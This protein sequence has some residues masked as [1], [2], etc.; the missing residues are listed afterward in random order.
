MSFF[1]PFAFVKSATIPAPAPVG[2]VANIID[3][4]FSISACYPGTGTTVTDLYGGFTGSL[5]NNPT[6]D[7]T[8]GSF[9]F[10]VSVNNQRISFPG[11]TT[12]YEIPPS[13]SATWNVWCSK[14]ST[15]DNFLLNK[16]P[17]AGGGTNQPGNYELASGF[18]NNRAAFITNKAN[19]ALNYSLPAGANFFG[20]GTDEWVN[21]II[22]STYNGGTDIYTITHYQN[23]VLWG[24]EGLNSTG[25][26]VSTPAEPLRIG[27]RKDNYA[28]EGRVAVVKIY[29][30][31]LT[32]AEILTY[33]D[34]TKARFGL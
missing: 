29:D 10:N 2:P 20:A 34:S 9:T 26:F 21:W 11:S 22:T 1:T 6:Y 3:L 5:V 30:F 33:F 19:G 4:D 24:A 27:S 16:G 14:R 18:N 8:T 32:G 25:A 17:L 7:A 28:W 13:G 15:S 31:E 23:G 12:R